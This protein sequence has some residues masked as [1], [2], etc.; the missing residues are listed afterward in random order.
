MGQPAALRLEVRLQQGRCAPLA[1]AEPGTP[2]HGPRGHPADPRPRRSPRAGDQRGLPCP[3]RAEVPGRGQGDRR[4]DERLGAAGPVRPGGRLR[5]LPAGRPLHPAGP[6]RAGGAAA[7][8]PGEG[9]Q[10]HPGRTLQQRHPGIGPGAGSHLLL[11]ADAGG[12][13]GQGA[14]D[15]VGLRPSRRPAEGGGAAVRPGPSGGGRHHPRRPVGRG[16]GGEL[17]HGP[18]PHP[19]DAWAELREEGLIPE[20]A[21]TPAESEE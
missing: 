8:V 15:Q 5:L 9:Y 1:G 19:A 6:V 21:P 17:Q 2:G 3:G 7:A 16:G 4:G 10:H 12:G 11:R 20:E 13:P 14:Q 18:S